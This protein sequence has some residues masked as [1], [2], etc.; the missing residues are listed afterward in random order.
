MKRAKK[1]LLCFSVILVG[2]IAL[3]LILIYVL[4]KIFGFLYDVTT[5]KDYTY[6]DEY[7]KEYIRTNYV[8]ADPNLTYLSLPAACVRGDGESYYAIH[9]IP[10]DQ[11]MVSLWHRFI[12]GSDY[13]PRVMKRSSVNQEPVLDWTYDS[14]QFIAHKQIVEF[15]PGDLKTVRELGKEVCGSTL[16]K[17]DA[18]VFRVFLTTAL[19]SQNYLERDA[20]PFSLPEDSYGQILAIRVTFKEYENLVW[21]ARIIT[22]ENIRYLEMYIQRDGTYEPVYIPLPAEIVALIPQ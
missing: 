11:Y 20:L 22:H 14:V 3:V 17:I 2:I 5:P 15:A 21:D 13:S 6:P 7:T 10:L 8:L 12:G 9:N 1:I 19:E 16:A 18:A 4:G